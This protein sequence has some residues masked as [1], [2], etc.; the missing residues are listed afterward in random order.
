MDFDKHKDVFERPFGF[1]HIAKTGGSALKT[2]IKQHLDLT[3]E[4]NVANLGHGARIEEILEHQPKLKLCF[5]VRDPVD[6]FVS[7]FNSR[8]RGGRYGVHK[9]SPREE[10]VF[11]RFIRPNDLAEALSSSDGTTRAIAEKAMQAVGHLKRDLRFHLGSIEILEAAK[12]QIVFIGDQRSLDD[13]FIRFKEI[14]GMRP[15]IELPKDQ[16]GAHKAPDTM[17]KTLSALG[18]Q[19]IRQH[20]IR[21]YPLLEWCLQHRK[22][23]MA[24]SAG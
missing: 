3:G 14:V 1:L 2:A 12:D 8:F 20:Y 4:Q 11:S 19:N 21:D 24:A 7:A 15:D 18:E 23:L 13:D 22:E 9:W 6:R 10:K 5:V 17:S 16:V